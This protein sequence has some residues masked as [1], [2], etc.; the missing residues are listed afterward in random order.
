[1]Y[2]T[3]PYGSTAYGS[4]SSVVGSLFRS[5]VATAIAVIASVRTIQATE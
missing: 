5:V 3:T 2:G 1:M 4:G